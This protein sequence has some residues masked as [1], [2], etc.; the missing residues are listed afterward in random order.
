MLAAGLVGT[1]VWA[2]FVLERVPS[3]VPGLGIAAV[4]LAVVAGFVLTLPPLALD[5]RVQRTALGLGLAAA[6]AGSAAFTLATTTRALAGGDPTAGPVEASG[7]GRPVGDFGTATNASMIDYLVAN[8]G[9]ATWI[10]AAQGSGHAAAIQ[11]AAGAPVLTMGGF[12]GTDAAPTATQLRSLIASGE[13]RFVLVGSVGGP[14]GPGGPGGSRVREL[15]A[16][17][18]SACSAVKIGATASGG[19]AGATLYDCAGAV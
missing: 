13:L 9:S 8:R 3:F 1:A 14:G 5:R 7:G 10:V 11:L 4:V 19:A 6:L 16:W 15:S 12:S 18:S 2:W 17:V